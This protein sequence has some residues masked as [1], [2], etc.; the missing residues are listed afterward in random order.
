MDDPDS[1]REMA[2]RV[3]EGYSTWKP[4]PVVEINART[5]ETH[6]IGEEWTTDA[7]VHA[8]L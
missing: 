5:L 4:C 8:F 3:I 6:E 7:V 2:W 1:V